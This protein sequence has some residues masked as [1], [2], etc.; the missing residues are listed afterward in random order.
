WVTR[1]VNQMFHVVLNERFRSVS[2]PAR[3]RCADIL[4]DNPTARSASQKRE[5]SSVATLSLIALR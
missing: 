2:L 5:T 4:R 1:L 3:V